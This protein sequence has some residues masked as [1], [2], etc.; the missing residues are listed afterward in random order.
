ML[1]VVLLSPQNELIHAFG[2]NQ[3]K[4]HFF[5]D[6]SLF[7]IKQSERPS[8]SSGISSPNTL[9][10]YSSSF[11]SIK[12]YYCQKKQENIIK[13]NNLENDDENFKFNNNLKQEE[14]QLNFNN[15][16]GNEFLLY[17]LLPLIAI[18]RANSNNNQKQLLTN[19]QS[20]T[21]N[22]GYLQINI[23]YLEYYFI[24]IM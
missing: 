9:F 2:N 12:S 15:S 5:G 4:K 6:G 20:S 10:N 1:G 14:E 23:E 21:L 24:L 11:S 17:Q 22:N 7:Q 18:C 16:N 8:S 13:N 3:F 19:I